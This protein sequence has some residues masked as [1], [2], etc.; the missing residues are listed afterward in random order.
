MEFKLCRKTS[1]SLGYYFEIKFQRVQCRRRITEGVGV[2]RISRFYMITGSPASTRLKTTHDWMI[3][4]RFPPI[5]VHRVSARVFPFP[6]A[7]N[8]T[9][10]LSKFNKCLMRLRIM[11]DLRNWDVYL[12]F[13]ICASTQELP[14]GWEMQLLV[15]WVKSKS[16]VADS[17]NFA[18]A[19]ANPE[20]P[21]QF[22]FSSSVQLCPLELSEQ[23]DAPCDRWNFKS[24]VLSVCR[25]SSSRSVRHER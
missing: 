23:T 18:P 22:A 13:K 5:R 25:F 16:T 7:N 15:R 20:V 2:K 21:E 14:I 9:L 19:W 11:R 17:S 1:A 12:D 6:A 3:G 10:D 24:V 4:K 8:R